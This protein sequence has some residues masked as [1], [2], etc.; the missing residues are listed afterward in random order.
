MPILALLPFLRISKKL[1]CLCATTAGILVIITMP[2]AGQFWS[3]PFQWPSTLTLISIL[4][5]KIHVFTILSFREIIICALDSTLW[6]EF[7]VLD[8][9]QIDQSEHVYCNPCWLCPWVYFL[10]DAMHETLCLRRWF[11]AKI[12]PIISFQNRS[13]FLLSQFSISLSKCTVIL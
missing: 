9:D 11:L 8:S 5:F 13:D 3:V 6:N 7:L 10:A 4:S 2:G 1:Y 12:C